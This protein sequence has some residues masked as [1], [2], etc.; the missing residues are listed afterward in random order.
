VVSG[1]VPTPGAQ[2][3]QREHD[4]LVV[5]Q[6][7]AAGL[8][9]ELDGNEL[10]RIQRNLRGEGVTRTL[11]L[12]FLY[13][14]VAGDAEGSLRRRRTDRFFGYDEGERLTALQLLGRLAEVNPELD[15][16][17]LEQIGDDGPLVV[18]CGDHVAGVVDDQDDDADT[19]EIDLSRGD[20]PT[21]TVRGLVNAVNRLLDRIGIRERLVALRSDGRREMYLA[22]TLATA[23]TL[24]REDLLEE[25]DPEELLEHAG[26]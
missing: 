26:W 16:M 24:C 7:C 9:T 11:H 15:G 18:R 12:A 2:D 6:L 5:N 21:V 8:L 22:V 14:D 23:M 20:A 4:I 19:G 10:Q 17:Q 13:Y 3:A 1:L 25:E